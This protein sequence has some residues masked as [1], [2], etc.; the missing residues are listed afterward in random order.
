[1]LQL[2]LFG[3]AGFIKAPPKIGDDALEALAMPAV[4]NLVANFFRKLPERR[5]WI[6]AEIPAEADHGLADQLPVAPSPARN[7]AHEQRFRPIR[8]DGARCPI[9]RSADRRQFRWCGCGAG[10]G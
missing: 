7:R 10:R 8:P 6:E 3:P 1:H 5:G 2:F 4:E 9:S